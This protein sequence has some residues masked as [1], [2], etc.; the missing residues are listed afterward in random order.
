MRKQAAEGNSLVAA[1]A[2]LAF[3]G[4]GE[5]EV[6]A[7]KLVGHASVIG[8]DTSRSTGF[9]FGSGVLMLR[10]VLSSV[11]MRIAFDIAVEHKRRTN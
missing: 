3:V 11:E 6:R 2:F 9:V 1:M 10:K 8:A 4:L 7:G 5:A